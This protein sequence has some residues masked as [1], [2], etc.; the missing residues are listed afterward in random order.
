MSERENWLTPKQAADRLGISRNALINNSSDDGD[1]KKVQF[2]RLFHG[3][4]KGNRQYHLT[5]IEK[6]R[7]LLGSN[8]EA[9]RIQWRQMHKR[10][11]AVE[12]R[13]VERDEEFVGQSSIE[14]FLSPPPPEDSEFPD[15]PPG[16]GVSVRSA[17]NDYLLNPFGVDG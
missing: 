8:I 5:E 4:R 6:W 15:V 16:F 2:R 9:K 12:R 13:I 14:E 3:A 11:E 7:E 1:P 17:S 10:V